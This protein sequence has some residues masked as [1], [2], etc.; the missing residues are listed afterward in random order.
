MSYLP[1]TQADRERML[2][3]LG[4]RTVDELFA[5]IPS[6][7]RLDRELCLPEALT[8]H[9]LLEHLEELA[10]RN[11][12]AGRRSFLG[13]GA[14]RHFVPTIVDTVTG[15]SEF[16]TAYTPYQAEASQG[17]LQAI[18]EFQTMIARLTGMDVANASVYDGGTAATDAA[19]MAIAQTRRNKVLV[20]RGVHPHTRQILATYLAPG[21][22]VVEEIPLR[23]GLTQVPTVGSDVAAVLVQI[24][25]FLGLVEDGPA[26]CQAARQAGA[27]AIVVVNDP[28]SLAVLAAPGGY[29]ADLVCG[30][31]QPVGLPLSFGGPYV[32]FLAARKDYLRRMPGRLV[33]LTSDHEGRRGFCLT[34]QAREQH[35]RREKASSNICSNQGLC[36]L[37]V[38]VHL[39]LLGPE[40]LREAA[41]G[42]LSASAWARQRL[43][44]IPGFSV[45]FAGPSFHEFVLRC[46]VPPQRLL[47]GL[48]ERGILGGY[49]LGAEYPELADGLLVCCTELTRREDIEELAVEL[50]ALVESPVEVLR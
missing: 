2:Q 1:H 12:V 25:N 27:L 9:D 47:E 6:A 31:A 44:R 46:P 34:L 48:A 41:L 32:G 45:A 22:G 42:S 24:P 5:P 18:F 16:L 40:G 33:G 39:S 43:S 38:T 29:G 8:E 4:V 26:L 7:V 49:A 11:Q 21:G 17:T 37:A 23:D 35:I 3:V 28:V 20:S 13:A 14:Y 30:E 15:R 19:L 10:G 36:A 50:E